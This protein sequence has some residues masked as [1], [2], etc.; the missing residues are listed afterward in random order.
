MTSTQFMM[1]E[2]QFLQNVRESTLYQR[3]QKLNSLL[4][5][6][7]TCVSLAQKRD[8]L[9][10]LANEEKDEEKK[11]SLLK[12]ANQFDNELRNQDLMKE[13]LFYYQ[14]LRKLINTLCDGLTKEV[15]S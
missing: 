10:L 6:D 15:L 13:Y 2:S 7:E 1:E 8:E 3:I 4:N 12:Q 11:Q 14:K 9:L 5:E